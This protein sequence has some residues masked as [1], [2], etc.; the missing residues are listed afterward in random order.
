MTTV[1]IVIVVL[2]AAVIGAAISGTQRVDE[3][4][5]PIRDEDLL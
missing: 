2:L 3:D 4:G 5:N 1:F